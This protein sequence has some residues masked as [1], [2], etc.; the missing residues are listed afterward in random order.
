MDIL[1]PITDI[2]FRIENGINKCYDDLIKDGYEYIDGDIRDTC[3]GKFCALGVKKYNGNSGAPITN[4][5]GTLSKG[6]EPLEIKQDGCTYKMI[7]DKNC[8]GDLNKNS[9]GDYLYLYYTTDECN[10]RPI[11]DLIYGNYKVKKSTKKEVIQNSER[12]KNKFDLDFCSGR[13]LN[14]SYIFIIRAD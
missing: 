4:I 13:S 3:G 12:S 1:N 9:G 14:F 6:R 10:K 5:I 2:T 8:N 7:V 11:K